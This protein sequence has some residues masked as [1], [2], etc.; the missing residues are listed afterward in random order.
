MW[1]GGLGAGDPACHHSH[2][3]LSPSC[4]RVP[5][6]TPETPFG[7]PVFPAG[8]SQAYI[9]SRQP[10]PPPVLAP[11]PL[12]PVGS[13]QSGCP[14]GQSSGPSRCCWFQEFGPGRRGEGAGRMSLMLA[15]PGEESPASIGQ[16]RRA[17]GEVLPHGAQP[18]PAVCPHST[19][20]TMAP[21]FPAARQFGGGSWATPNPPPSKK[22]A[23]LTPRRTEAR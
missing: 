20:P 3:P 9:L 17:L 16:G 12:L 13:Q 11:V 7:L 5:G 14:R 21:L 15:V 19:T 23:G 6:L 10:P 2:N 8:G 1:S 22:R 18:V 4:L